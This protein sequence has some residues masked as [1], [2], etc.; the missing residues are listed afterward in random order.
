MTCHMNT[1][2][3]L[4]D[5]TALLRHRTRAAGA[6]ADFLHL[7]AIAEVK[8]RLAMVNR[9][10]TEMTIV[11]G[12]PK[13]WGTAFPQAHI[14]A[15]EDVLDVQPESRDL[16]VHAM[17]LHWAN[18]PVGQL[19]QCRRALRP[20]GLLLAV[21]FGG[22]TLSELRA[23]LSQAEIAVSGGLSP[24]IAPMGEIRDMGSLLQR[25]GLA[26]PVADGLP[27]QVEYRDLIHL[28]HDLR[29]MGETNALDQRH[30]KPAPHALFTEA[31]R[32][33]AEHFPGADSRIRATFE[34]LF[35]SGWAPDESQPKPLRPGSASHSLAAALGTNENPLKD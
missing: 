16:V 23:C 2:P 6:P 10:F 9:S 32:L 27:L 11:T 21:S 20:D 34:L 25:A 17:C 24:R 35:L 30:R 13:V 8:D 15:D 22:D 19:I 3:K 5:R 29:A 1:V 4:T 7:E 33:Y 26:M 12:H 14:V 18:D 28:M 31:Q